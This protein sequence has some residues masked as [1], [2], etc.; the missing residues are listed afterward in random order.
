MSKHT[1]GPWKYALDDDNSGVYFIWTNSDM[2]GSDMTA[3][4]YFVAG[5]GM[6]FCGDEERIK[7]DALLIAAA[8][9]LLDSIY[10]IAAKT[11]CY[12]VMRVA[13]GEIRQIALDAVS[14]ATS[15]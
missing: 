5:T 14:K 13:L 10:R 12:E 2:A 11:E 6:P 9:D 4:L 8:P 7:A 1:P 3:S 15:P